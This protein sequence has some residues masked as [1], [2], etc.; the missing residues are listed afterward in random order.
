MRITWR[1]EWITLRVRNERNKRNEDE[2]RQL[3]FTVFFIFFHNSFSVDVMSEWMRTPSVVFHYFLH[4]RKKKKNVESMS[5]NVVLFLISSYSIYVLKSSDDFPFRWRSE[6]RLCAEWVFGPSRSRS[7]INR[8]N[9][10][11]FHFPIGT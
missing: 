11:V 10:F 2:N 3:I 1:N 4:T 9:K 6:T 8:I 5:W 7:Y